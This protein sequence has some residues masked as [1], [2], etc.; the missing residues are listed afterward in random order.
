MEQYEYTCVE[1]ASEFYYVT[2][3]ACEN[4]KIKAAGDG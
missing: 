1:G 4:R 3:W 2:G